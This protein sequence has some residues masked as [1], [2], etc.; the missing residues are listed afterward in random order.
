ELSRPGRVVLSLY[1][2]TGRRIALLADRA[3]EAGASAV[4]WDGRDSSGREAPA[5]IYFARLD[6]DGGAAMSRVVKLR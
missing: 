6:T 2:V 3:F 1:D 5:G 4:T